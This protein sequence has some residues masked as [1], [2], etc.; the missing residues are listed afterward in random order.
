MSGV[1]PNKL[2][3]WYIDDKVNMPEI[4]SHSIEEWFRKLKGVRML[5]WICYSKL[6]ELAP[7]FSLARPR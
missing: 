6:E 5:D 7:E 2:Q 4:I 1:G 3:G